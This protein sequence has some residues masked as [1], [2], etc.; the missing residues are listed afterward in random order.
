MRR[1]QFLIGTIQTPPSRAA[2]QQPA[3]V[4][5][6]HRYDPNVMVRFLQSGES[7]FQF[8]IGTIQTMSSIDSRSDSG[9]FNSS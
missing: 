8:L 7:Q 9:G 1:F 5:I 4:S 3:G 2:P 6:P